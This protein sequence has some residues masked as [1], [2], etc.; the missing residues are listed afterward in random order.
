M[1]KT[2][3]DVERKPGN[4]VISNERLSLLVISSINYLNYSYS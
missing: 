3:K 1:I 2:N 4:Q